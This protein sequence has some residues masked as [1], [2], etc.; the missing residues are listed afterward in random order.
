[1]TK[2]LKKSNIIN[3][4]IPQ[5]EN[6]IIIIGDTGEGKSTLS[7]YLIG[8]PLFSKE[9]DL[10]DYTICAKDPNEIDI[11]AGPTSQTSLPTCRGVYWDYPGFGDTRG[12][13]QNIVNAYSIY[14]LVKNVERLKILLVVSEST[15]LCLVVTKNNKLYANKVRNCFRKILGE[16]DNQSFSQPKREI[17]NYLSSS[18]SQIVFF[19]APEQENDQISNTDKISILE[20]IEKISYLKNLEPKI[21]LDDKSNLYIN[22][23]VNRFYEDIKNYIWLR[24]YPAIQTYFETLIDTHQGTVKDLIYDNPENFEENLQQILLIVKLIQ[25]NDLEEELLKKISLLNFFKLVKSESVEINGNTDSWYSYLSQLINEIEILTT[26]PK[27][28][29]QE[30]LLVLEGIIVG[31][32]D[33]SIAMNDQEF[34]E[35]NVFSLNS[36]FIDK[37]I[38]AP[39]IN[40]TLVSP[41]WH[42]VG[43]RIINLK[44]NPGSL[45]QPNKANDGIPST[46]EQINDG[47]PSTREQ[48]ND[49]MPSTREQINDGIPST[50]EQINDGIP[51]TR[52]QINDD[53]QINTNYEITSIEEQKISGEDGLPGLPGY[54]GGNFYDRV[55]N[56]SEQ[57]L[58][59]RKKVKFFSDKENTETIDKVKEYSEK[60]FKFLLTCNDKHEET[61]EYFDPG[62][63]GGNENP[64]IFKESKRGTN[65]KGGKPGHGGKNGQKYF[66]T[67]VG[68]MEASKMTFL[69][70][71]LIDYGFKEATQKL[72]FSTSGALGSLGITF[73]A[74]AGISAISAK[75]SSYWKEGPYEVDNDERAPEG[76]LLDEFNEDNIKL[77]SDH[78][79]LITENEKF[80]DQYKNFKFIKELLC[81]EKIAY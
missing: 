78:L 1:M 79:L 62:L 5:Q 43:K 42:V 61:Y 17:L 44:G 39:G 15:G 26:L 66:G 71:F 25:R 51:S 47:I 2:K 23:L 50:G 31:T 68:A 77:P 8:I 72:A 75:Y 22:D 7:G 11:N 12:P 3:D 36:L 9:D 76:K 28:Y 32:E 60:V 21:L 69:E 6:A 33:L 59:S 16:Y 40:L 55:K 56:K 20:S 49:G 10:G 46:R 29:N 52:E 35:I 19:N 54:N 64:I 45:H 65:G 81:L 63:K 14:K 27:I 73:A 80:Y 24:F 4:K 53:K 67:V 70:K 37:D 57:A 38:I 58:V 41:Q 18:E 30:H 13:V 74:Q 48:I 34:S